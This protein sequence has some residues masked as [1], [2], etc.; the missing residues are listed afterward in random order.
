VT[1]ARQRRTAVLTAAARAKS[2]AKTNAAER[3]IRALVGR[4]EPITVQA[5]MREAGVSHAFLYTHPE[6][7]ER[8]EHLRAAPSRPAPAE[9]AAGDQQDTLVLALT[10][11]LTALK[12]QHRQEVHALRTALEQAHGENLELRRELDRRRPAQPSTSASP[13]SRCIDR[14]NVSSCTNPHSSRSNRG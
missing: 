14:N 4:G 1:D 10:A 13:Q 6:L 3:G 11:Q 12:K 2:Q 5:V 7:R 8:I 9:Q